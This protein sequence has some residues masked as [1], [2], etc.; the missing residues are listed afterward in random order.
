[1]LPLRSKQDH[2]RLAAESAATASRVRLGSKPPGLRARA[3]YR[4]GYTLMDGL[5]TAHLISLGL[6]GGVVL[7][8]IV[9]ELGG[10]RGR[11]D[12]ASVAWL[13]AQVDRLVEAPLLLAVVGTGLLLWQRAGW[14]A[15]LLPKVGAGLAAVLANVVCVGL[16]M[17]RASQP[18]RTALT[19]GVFASALIGVPFAILALIL[20]GARAGW[21]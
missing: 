12:R 7:V 9:F 17:R 4:Q 16:V 13:H 21:W 10:L 8:E 6:W 2:G 15:G 18:Q 19:R 3:L 1:M 20:G 14:S 5:L 11:L